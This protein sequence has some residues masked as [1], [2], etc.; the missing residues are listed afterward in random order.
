M[1]DSKHRFELP[2]LKA[3]ALCRIDSR[4]RYAI[5]LGLR[6]TREAILIERNP[7]NVGLK[8]KHK[9]ETARQSEVLS[10]LDIVDR[11]KTIKGEYHR[12]FADNELVI[13]L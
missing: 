1:S 8:I 5:G 9:I 6:G 7:I 4:G 2:H 3:N 12:V 13:H 11:S 10:S